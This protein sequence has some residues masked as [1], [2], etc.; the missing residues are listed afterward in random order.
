MIG[1]LAGVS[2]GAPGQIAWSQEPLASVKDRL[3]HEVT[4]QPT[5]YDLTFE[6]VKVSNQLGDYEASIGVL[7]RLLFYNPNLARIRYEIG[8]LYYRL[9]SFE[10]AR[11]YFREA[12]ANPQLD[13]ATRERIETYLPLAEK[14]LQPSRISGFLQAGIRTQSNPAFSPFGGFVRLG[15]EDFP[16]LPNAARRKADAGLFAI[17][18][19]SHDYDFQNQRGDVLETRFIGYATHQFKL[20]RYDLGFFEASFGPRLAIAP[21]TLPGW[22]AKPYVVGG[23]SAFDGA[24]FSSGG[25][26]LTFGIPVQPG[27][28]VE[29][30][31]E[32]RQASYDDRQTELVVSTLGS[33]GTLAAGVSSTFKYMEGVTFQ[34]RTTYRHADARLPWQSFDQFI[35]EYAVNIEFDPPITQVPRRWSFAPFFR[36][37]N[38]R[39]NAPNPIVDAR[40]RRRDNE[41]RVGA[42]LEAPLTANFGVSALVQYGRIS[43]NLPNYRTDNWSFAIGP[44]ARF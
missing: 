37:I 18:G 39:F 42:Q 24:R 44:T 20:D 34:S 32:W 11:R 19:F 23:A 6:F 13:P 35:S 41:W 36:L 26:G 7:E 4:R 12:L 40:V 15:G 3:W 27:W 38:T 2:V 25:A 33:A 5:N 9:G 21:E 29:P 43:S 8:S 16:L 22:T 10:M 14:Q 1:L 17:A 28:T 30:F 31:V